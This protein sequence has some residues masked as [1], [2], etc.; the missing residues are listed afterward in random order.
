MQN[1]KFKKYVFKI[2]QVELKAILDFSQDPDILSVTLS[3]CRQETY[4]SE[5]IY[6]LCRQLSAPL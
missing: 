3:F 1:Y 2:D 5:I 6:S 4:L